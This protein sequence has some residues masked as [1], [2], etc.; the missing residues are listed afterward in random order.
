MSGLCGER[1]VWV[2]R[3]KVEGTSGGGDKVTETL[4]PHPTESRLEMTKA[5]GRFLE[6]RRVGNSR[7]RMRT[8]R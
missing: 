2:L 8:E 1:F 7:K 6:R 5:K 3:K 4:H